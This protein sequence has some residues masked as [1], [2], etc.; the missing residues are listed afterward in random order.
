MW[1]P[2]SGPNIWAK[3]RIPKPNDAATIIKLGFD[4]LRVTIAQP[5]HNSTNK[6]IAMNSAKHARK[7]LL[8]MSSQIKN[9]RPLKSITVGTFRGGI[10]IDNYDITRSNK[11][12]AEGSARKFKTKE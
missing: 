4:K 11:A 9:C 3:T 5:Q 6:C 2:D 8:S 10:L 7:N 1:P 12:G